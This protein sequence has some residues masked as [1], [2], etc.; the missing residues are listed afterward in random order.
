MNQILV[1]MDGF[2]TNTSI[3]I[4]AA[5]NRPD[6]LDPALLRPG[7]FDRRVAVD[8]PDTEGR[9]AI[10]ELHMKG[11]PIAEGID[12]EKIARLTPGFSGADLANLVNEAA[13]L[14]ARENRKIIIFKDFEESVDRVIAGPAKRSKKVS[15][16]ERA[17]KAY[18][19]A[20][21]AVVAWKLEYADPVHRISIVPRGEMGGYTRMLPDEERGLPDKAYLSDVLAV[22][23]GGRVSEELKY[24]ED[25][26]TTGASDD[27]EKATQLARKMI[28]RYGMSSLGPRTFGQREELV[29]LGREIR[30]RRDYSEDTAMKIDNEL[31]EMISKATKRAKEAIEDSKERIE[32]IV[33]ILLDKETLEGEKLLSIL[34]RKALA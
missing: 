30:E 34:P 1:E 20:G 12:S 29:F 22:M 32:N 19:E 9:K 24:G 15:Q 33:I 6:I 4:I 23:M 31:R 2:E 28:T 14:A 11:K 5:T 3:V 13:I 18:H 17:I 8:I 7:R 27:L 25:H 10:L 16:K 26:I 21:H